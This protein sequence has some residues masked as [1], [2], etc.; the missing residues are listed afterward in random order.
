MHPCYREEAQEIKKKQW[1]EKQHLLTA[2][3]FTVQH[4]HTSP[5]FPLLPAG[6]FF[7]QKQQK[8]DN[9]PAK[10]TKCRAFTAVDVL[11]KIKSLNV[12][13]CKLDKIQLLKIWVRS[14]VKRKGDWPWTILLTFS[15]ACDWVTLYQQFNLFSNALNNEVDLG[16][17]L[18]EAI[19]SLHE[20]STL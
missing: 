20:T 6:K 19:N 17:F 11:V 16:N 7:G 15:I 1:S 18:C 8:C 14:W 9:R 5:L 13:V 12:D 3:L 10:Q 2:P 4:V